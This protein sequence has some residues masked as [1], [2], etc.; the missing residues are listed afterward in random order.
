MRVLSETALQHRVTAAEHGFQC[1]KIIVAREA[2]VCNRDKLLVFGLC[3]REV[4]VPMILHDQRGLERREPIYEVFETG[5]HIPGI[6]RC[7][8]ADHVGRL[9]FLK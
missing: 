8:E 9:I 5:R 7:A 4:K 1:L 3:V 6:D 2:A